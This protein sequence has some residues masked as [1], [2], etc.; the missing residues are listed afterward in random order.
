VGIN[1]GAGAGISGLARL[2]ASE[3]AFAGL[4]AGPDIGASVARVDIESMQRPVHSTGLRTDI[5]APFKVS[6]RAT[7]NDVAGL[8]SDTGGGSFGNMT[9]EE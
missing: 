9:F 6:G 2:S 8:V 1:T 4:R 7:S 5:N 3:G